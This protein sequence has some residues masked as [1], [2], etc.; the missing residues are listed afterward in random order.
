MATQYHADPSSYRG[1]GA[2]WLTVDAETPAH[3]RWSGY[4]DLAPDG[5]PTPLEAAP[6]FSSPQDAVAWGRDRAPRV[7]L[8]LVEDGGYFWAGTGSMPAEDDWLEG[9]FDVAAIRTTTT[10]QADANS[11]ETDTLEA[12]RLEL[13]KAQCE[14]AELMDRMFDIENELRELREHLDSD[15]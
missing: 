14:R 5:P 3:P 9:E 8:R 13:E 10:A 2:V 4:W 15:D 7:Y 12:I 11:T 1:Q 6:R